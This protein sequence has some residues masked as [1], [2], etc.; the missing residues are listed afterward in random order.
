MNEIK[1]RILRMLVKRTGRPEYF[2]EMFL[3]DPQN[4]KWSRLVLAYCAKGNKETLLRVM[5]GYAGGPHDL[6]EVIKADAPVEEAPAE[7][8]PAEAEP[9][10]QAEAPK[11]EPIA[12]TDE[13]GDGEPIEA[14]AEAADAPAETPEPAVEEAPAEEAAPATKKRKAT[15]K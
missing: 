8:A 2:T 7:A 3:K 15:K 11:D 10:A 12:D 14:P 5:N 6:T 13:A 4:T 9:V 1:N